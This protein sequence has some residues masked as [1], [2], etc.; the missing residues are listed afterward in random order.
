[1]AAHPAAEDFCRAA[2][3]QAFS[4]V[5]RR[6]KFLLLHLENGGDIV[7]HLRMTG[8]LLLTPPDISPEKHTHAVFYLDNGSQLRFSDMR[9]FGRL[10]LKR[11]GEPDTFTGICGL[12][13]EPFDPDVDAAYLLRAFG[14]SRRPI[15][16]CL[17]DQSRI[18]GIGN[19][20]ADEI[21]FSV[22]IHPARPAAT[23]RQEEWARPVSYTH[24]DG[25]KRQE[26]LPAHGIDARIFG[27]DI[28]KTAVRYAAKRC[29]AVSF[30]AAS[31]FSIPCAERAA[32]GLIDLFAPIVPAEFARV[33]RPGGFML[34]AV[35]GPRHLYA[36]KQQLY[37]R[38]YEN[39][40]REID[41][42]GFRRCGRERVS[43]SLRLSRKQDI[44]NPVSYKHL[45]VYK[46]QAP[47]RPRVRRC[48]QKRRSQ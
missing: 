22:R 28:G 38:P 31:A 46:R 37:E 18:A 11:P 36:L 43:F 41:Y 8:Q 15:K 27:F 39:E 14:R 12:G 32:D 6:G 42:P 47:G 7:V 1:M 4:A 48:P 45:D 25:Y 40:S 23:L 34:L 3:G 26:Y 21:L 29:R 13:P 33:V 5:N 9:R 19:I 10:W 24:L 35:P 30:A 16:A 20:Y 17:L 2:G 44:L